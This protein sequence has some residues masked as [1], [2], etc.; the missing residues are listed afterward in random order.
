MG[1]PGA[2]AADAAFAADAEATEADRVDLA[3]L[4]LELRQQGISDRRVLSAIESIPRRFFID[5]AHRGLAYRNSALPIECGQTISQPAV[6]AMM[7][8]ALRLAPHHKVLEI[9]TGSGYQAAVL[10]RLVRKVVS[11]ERYRHLAFLARQR[12]AALHLGNVEVHVADG[13]EGWPERAPY[14]RI[15]VTAAAGEV[16]PGLLGQLA[17]EGILVAPLGPPGGVQTLERIEKRGGR[18]D[19]VRLASVRFVPLEKGVAEHL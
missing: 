1:D 19:R 13:R 18:L 11:V 10:G 16:P 3:E 15:V 5:R 14:D 6:V 12:L 8:E 17:D 4:I 9:G 7:T 2:R